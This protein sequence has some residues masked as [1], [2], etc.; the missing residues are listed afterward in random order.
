MENNEINPEL[1]AIAKKRAKFKMSVYTYII[2]NI[3][4]WCIWLFTKQ[5]KTDENSF[6]PWPAWATLG[7]GIA[8]ALQYLDAYKSKG[9]T[10]IN[11]EYEKL[12]KEEENKV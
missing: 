4:L 11:K 12:K 2:I 5:E 10:A 7:W 3:F 1:W 9:N 6:I 8:I